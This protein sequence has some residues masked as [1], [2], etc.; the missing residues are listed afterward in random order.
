MLIAED[1]HY[2]EV[3]RIESNCSGSAPSRRDRAVFTANTDADADASTLKSI[4]EVY[5]QRGSCLSRE[6]SFRSDIG[7]VLCPYEGAP[8]KDSS[9]EATTARTQ[10]PLLITPARCDKAHIGIITH[11]TGFSV[12]QHA[13]LYY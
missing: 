7:G 3:K 11:S 5:P 4:Y 2:Q 13:G 10:W 8:H 9:R 12:M 1:A 6:R